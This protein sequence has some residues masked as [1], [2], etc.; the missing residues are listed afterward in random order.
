MVL[1][2]LHVL[3][4][5]G[6]P[7]RILPGDIFLPLRQSPLLNLFLDKC[8]LSHVDEGTFSPLKLLQKLSLR[9]NPDLCMENLARATANIGSLSNASLDLSLN[10]LQEIPTDVLASLNS[11]L[12][13][14][15]LRG[16]NV[17]EIRN[18]SFPLL[19]VLDV[20]DLSLC[21]IRAIGAGTF[22]ALP[23][24]RTLDLSQ[25]KLTG[26][27]KAIMLST[28]VSLVLNENP[29]YGYFEMLQEHGDDDRG[30]DDGFFVPPFENMD[31]L[32]ALSLSG[33]A[34]RMQK[35]TK[36]MFAGLKALMRLDLNDCNLYSIETGAFSALES[37]EILDM[38]GNQL[39]IENDGEFLGLTELKALFLHDNHIS[40][41]GATS[42]FKTLRNLTVLKLNRNSMTHL[43]E[44]FFAEM[45]TM[46]TLILSE[47]DIEQ[48][49]SPVLGATKNMHNLRLDRNKLV[50]VTEAMLTDFANLAT[51]DLSG[52]PFKCDCGLYHFYRWASE[53][54]EKLEG[55]LEEGAYTC[56]ANNSTQ[57]SF[58][59]DGDEI[60]RD[61][62][63]SGDT[64]DQAPTATK[65]GLIIAL[66]VLVVHVS[67]V[68]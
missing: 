45:E 59:L 24:L 47:N 15:F 53:N 4:L 51:L 23:H 7:F 48:W 52:N 5:S 19:P 11:T 12:M 30:Y 35:I 64:N 39:E 10:E 9:G 68:G 34:I 32:L 25:N 57:Y 42:P 2:E 33:T 65:A 38:S 3:R 21:R 63:R 67:I 54:Q 20:L 22:D 16:C 61:C 17:G 13:Q 41:Q 1:P 62:V 44:D 6:N 60:F 28:L 55:W 29:Y 26:V 49:N 27:P 66:S 36:Y 14:L 46:E 37:L 58:L 40:S 56:W 18:G 50:A 8:Q 43:T 31:N